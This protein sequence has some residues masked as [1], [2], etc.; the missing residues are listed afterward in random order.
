[1]KKTT[2]NSRVSDLIR[3]LGGFEEIHGR[4]GVVLDEK[5]EAMRRADVEAMGELEH[6]ERTIVDQLKERDGLRK[7]LMDAIGV[8]LGLP[9]KAGRTLNLTQLGLRLSES[10]RARLSEAGAQLRE[11]VMKVRQMER[12]AATVSREVANHLQWVLSAVRPRDERPGV[13][14]NEGALVRG[15]GSAMVEL[16]G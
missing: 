14:S 2:T 4:L 1:M 3:L 5:I 11:T 8:D 15:G 9:P 16:V 7:Q 13:Y 10:E 12:V 6:R